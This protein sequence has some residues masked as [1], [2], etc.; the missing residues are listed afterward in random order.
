MNAA[1]SSFAL[2]PAFQFPLYLF[3][4]IRADD[5][6][7]VA[8]HI[9]LRNFTLIDLFLLGEEV[10]RIGLLQERIALVFLI[11]KDAADGSGI[12]FI[13]A[14]RR[15]D[16]VGGKLGGDAIGRHSLQEHTVDASDNDR[17]FGIQHQVAVRATVITQEPLERYGDLTV[18]K[19]FPLTPGAVFGDGAAFFLGKAGH[20]GNQQFALGIQRPDILFLEINLHAFFFQLPDGSQAVDRVS[21]KP[22]DRLGDDEIY[23]IRLFDTM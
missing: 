6:F 4:H 21:G 10:N 18:C 13:F 3:E 1:V 22:A 19:P 14:T 17:L 16:P 9:V 8:F 7:V 5:G 2:F 11:G 20:N 15:L 12:P 23:F